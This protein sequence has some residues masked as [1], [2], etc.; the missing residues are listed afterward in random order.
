MIR[1]VLAMIFGLN[2]INS[3][4]DFQALSPD[5]RPAVFWIEVFGLSIYEAALI[6]FYFLA[7]AEHTNR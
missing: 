4:T 5:V 2:V 1:Y 6:L 3:I 7:K